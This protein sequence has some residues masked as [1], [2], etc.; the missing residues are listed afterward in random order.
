MDKNRWVKKCKEI[1]VGNRGEVDHE[2]FGMQL[3]E[4]IFMLNIQSDITQ[5]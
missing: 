2:I 4:A 5:E 3:Y 1:V